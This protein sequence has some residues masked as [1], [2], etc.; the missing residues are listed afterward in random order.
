MTI[1]SGPRIGTCRIGSRNRPTVQAT[2]TFSVTLHV[3]GQSHGFMHLISR[4]VRSDSCTEGN[5]PFAI[6]IFRYPFSLETYLK[7]LKI[8]SIQITCILRA[9]FTNTNQRCRISL[10]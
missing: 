5:S 3:Y 7:F 9:K 4:N 2:A 6:C 1:F 8:V 10:L